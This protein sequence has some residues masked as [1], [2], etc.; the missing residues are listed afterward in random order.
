MLARNSDLYFEVSASCS[1]FSSS[2]LPR[3]LDLA[4]L[5]LDLARS[6][7]PSS[8]AL[9]LLLAAALRLRRFGLQLV[10]ARLVAALP[11]AS[12]A[13]RQRLR[14]LEQLL[15]AHVR[16]DRVEHDADDLG[17]LVEERSGGS[18]LN[19]LEGGELDDGLDLRL[20]RGP[21]AR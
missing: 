12:A 8:A 20:R 13:P 1:A 6:A 9:F 7:R 11:A 10:A 16:L 21:A 18:S 19:A 5:A 3:L 17:E 14:L 2:A 15:G 4:V